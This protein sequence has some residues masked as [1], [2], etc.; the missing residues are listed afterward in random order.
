MKGAPLKVHLYK[1]HLSPHA[2]MNFEPSTSGL[3]GAPFKGAPFCPSKDAPT[4]LKPKR[5][6][7]NDK[8]FQLKKKKKE[9]KNGVQGGVPLSTADTNLPEE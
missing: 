7:K 6:T 1:V 5:K 3:K 2:R 9:M 4:S 8:S